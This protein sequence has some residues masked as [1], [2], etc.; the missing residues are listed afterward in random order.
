M[1]TARSTFGV[2]GTGIKIGIISDSYGV[3]SREVSSQVKAGDLPGTGNPC[4]HTTPVQIVADG[5]SGTDEGRAMAQIVHDLAPAAKLLFGDSGASQI[6]MANHVRALRDAGAQVIVDDIGY[7]DN[8]IYQNGYLAAAVDEVVADGVTYLSSAGNQN[9][10]VGGKSVGSYETQAFRPTACP[11]VI[12]TES[13]CHDFDPG[14]GVSAK[15]VVT[16][17]RGS[18][19][20]L[21]LGWNEP[22]YDVDSDLDLFLLDDA[23]GTILDVGGADSPGSGR[24]IEWAFYENEGTTSKK[25][26]IVVANYG[27]V[28]TPRFKSIFYTPALSSVQW[29]TAA[30]GDV[31]GPTLYGHAASPSTIA[32]GAMTPAASPAIE[33]FSSRGPA[34]Q[35][36]EPAHGLT[37]AAAIP[38]CSTKTI[39][40]L[41]TDGIATTVAGFDPFYGTSAAAPHVAAV[42]ALMKQH[43]PCARPADIR[44]GLKGGAIPLGTVDAG[45]SGR[46]DAF[47]ALDQLDGCSPEIGAPAAPVVKAVSATSVQVTIA[48][49]TVSEFPAVGYEL[50]LVRPGG[51]VVATQAASGAGGMA[52]F[53]VD[54][55]VEVGSAYRVRARTDHV[56][57]Q[58]PWSPSSALIVPPFASSAAFLSRL[59][60]DFTGGTLSDDERQ[61]LTF[62][63]GDDYGPSHAAVEASYFE[64]WAPKL[65]PVTRLFLAYFL[66]K[67]DPS[68][69]NYWLGKRRA[70]LT[71]DRI[72][73]NFA[74]SSEFQRRY[75]ALTNNQFVKLVYQN[76]LSRSGDASGIAYW[77][78]QLDTRKRDR[79]QVMTGFSESSEHLRRRFG[80]YTTIDLFFGMLRRIPTNAE[81][82]EWV[83]VLAADL[84][85]DTGAGTEA[86]ARELFTSAE[87]LDRVS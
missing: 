13:T 27:N 32:V 72:S 49:P 74:A 18:S 54:V 56:I 83:P 26:R 31:F 16:V 2:D 19:L 73:S 63:L 10:T 12:G 37:P 71:L 75:G 59:G 5:A 45:G 69:L 67:P 68:G 15:D 52:S 44:A 82:A 86:L 35:C 28:G 8:T 30:G 34:T 66:R 76:V 11:S 87:Y 61:I 84:Q 85:D 77:T 6:E 23:T 38:G 29:N 57:A 22:I 14:S 80:E 79:G 53:T 51:E 3:D 21:N 7:L 47:E 62:V 43:A 70:G 39:D 81:M 41:G 65:D 58:S 20:V 33:T 1:P 55:P 78:K 40:L 17:P 4:G 24:P 64:D 60:Q 36:W 25:V 46:T 42:A 50:Q 48:A 9:L